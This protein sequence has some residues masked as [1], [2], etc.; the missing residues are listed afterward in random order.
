ME[1]YKIEIETTGKYEVK[2]EFNKIV[3]LTERQYL[4]LVSVVLDFLD[5]NKSAIKSFGGEA[6]DATL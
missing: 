6:G 4:A 2:K 3:S 1:E 5:T